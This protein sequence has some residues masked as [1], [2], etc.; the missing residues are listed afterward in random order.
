VQP[1]CE[2]CV[3][4]PPTTPRLARAGRPAGAGLYVLAAGT[5]MVDRVCDVCAA[6]SYSTAGNVT[7]CTSKTTCLAG[8]FV[9]SEGTTTTDRTCAACGS[10]SFSTATNAPS[11]T[12]WTTCGNGQCVSSHGTATT[13]RICASCA[14]FLLSGADHGGGNWTLAGG[15]VLAGNH[16]NIGIFT[17]PAGATVQVAPST[18][19]TTGLWRYTLQKSIFLELWMATTP[20]ILRRRDQG[21]AAPANS[22]RA[23]AVAAMAAPAGWVEEA[24]ARLAGPWSSWARNQPLVIR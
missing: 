8:T 17:I 9:A 12:A 10:G 13:D 20:G 19:R 4:V 23:G 11:C 7:S 14:G 5:T 24:S 22:V 1:L 15:E 18:V 2:R 3:Q 21:Q 6:G 16:Q